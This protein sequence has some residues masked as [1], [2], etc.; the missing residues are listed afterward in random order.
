MENS[1]EAVRREITAAGGVEQELFGLQHSGL[2]R[3]GDGP[4]LTTAQAL[5]FVREARSAPADREG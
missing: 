2:W 3:F 1:I 5:Q 4:E